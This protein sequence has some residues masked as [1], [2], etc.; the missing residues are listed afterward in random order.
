[1][2]LFVLIDT[3]DQNIMELLYRS[4]STVIGLSRPCHA[5]LALKIIV[6]RLASFAK[7][8][9]IKMCLHGSADMAPL[10]Q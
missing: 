9:P 10:G 5:T 2:F 1:M 7:R 8:L 3:Q 6:E 4:P